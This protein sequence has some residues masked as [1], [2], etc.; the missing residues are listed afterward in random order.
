[1]SE[2]KEAEPAGPS[3]AGATRRRFHMQPTSYTPPEESD[4]RPPKD[5]K[6]REGEVKPNP[7]QAPQPEPKK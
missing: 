3:R 2:K 5:E 6:S 1:V 4:P 7:K